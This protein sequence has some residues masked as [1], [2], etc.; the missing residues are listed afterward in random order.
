MMQVYQAGSKSEEVS[1]PEVVWSLITT[2]SLNEHSN[3]GRRGIILL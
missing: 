2:A 1:D 3:L